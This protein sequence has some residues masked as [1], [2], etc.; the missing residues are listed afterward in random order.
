MY[1]SSLNKFSS[2]LSSSRKP[3]SP[4]DYSYQT[5]EFRPSPHDPSSTIIVRTGPQGT[6]F[7]L[8]AF[9]KS[10]KTKPHL[11]LYRIGAG[12]TTLPQTFIG[13]ATIKSSSSK[14]DMTLQ[15]EP[16][17]LKM[18]NSGGYKFMNSMGE[19]K[20]DSDSLLSSTIALA[21]G[22]GMKLARYKAGARL[23]VLVSCDDAFLD[24]V[25]LS[26]LSAAGIKAK[27]DK[28]G[29]IAGEIISALV[30]G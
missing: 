16:I 18:G 29:E 2:K 21:D 28:N 12:N 22:S 20:W 17:K 9:T 14:V 23:D 11:F 6:A 27:D 19:F 1:G 15:G 5:L 26:A 8:F 7:P 3:N 10:K 25:V 4:P 13:D 30:G 24:L